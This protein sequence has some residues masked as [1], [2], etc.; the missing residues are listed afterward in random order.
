MDREAK[1]RGGM[2]FVNKKLSGTHTSENAGSLRRG[3]RGF[4]L[5]EM[6][7]VLAIILIIS[8]IGFITLQPSLKDQRLTTAYNATLMTLRRARQLAVDQGQYHAEHPECRGCRPP[9]Q[10]NY[11]SSRRSVS[12]GGSG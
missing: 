2:T 1:R 6:S 9:Y 5:L 12:S 11:P 8:C 4:S 7:V 3:I 10:H